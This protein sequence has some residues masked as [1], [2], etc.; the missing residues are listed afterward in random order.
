MP[1]CLMCLI[2]WVHKTDSETIEIDM[3]VISNLKKTKISVLLI[4]FAYSLGEKWDKYLDRV[5]EAYN[6]IPDIEITFDRLNFDM[7]KEDA[8][9]LTCKI[10]EADVLYIWWWD[11]IQLYNALNEINIKDLLLKF[12]EISDKA[13]IGKSAWAIVLFDKFIYPIDDTSDYWLTNWLWYVKWIACAHFSEKERKL[14]LKKFS[15]DCWEYGI[16][17]DELC[18]LIISSEGYTLVSI[19]DWATCWYYNPINWEL[20]DLHTN[21]LDIDNI[22]KNVSLLA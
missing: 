3:K 1:N 19:K 21:D 22:K 20:K 17:I 11:P 2:G 10:E 6:A 14:V 9:Y 16:W 15:D 8:S 4:D 12:I 13:I 7:S 18:G 5:K